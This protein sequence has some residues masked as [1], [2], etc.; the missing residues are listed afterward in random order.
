VAGGAPLSS[1]VEA[2]GKLLGKTLADERENVTAPEALQ[3]AIDALARVMA[4]L[5]IT[6]FVSNR[7]FLQPR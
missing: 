6:S 1:I 7:L 4:P 3:A 2:V 5:E